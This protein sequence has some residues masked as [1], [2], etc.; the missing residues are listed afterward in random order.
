MKPKNKNRYRRQAQFRGLLTVDAKQWPFGRKAKGS[1]KVIV[2]LLK[3]LGESLHKET[4][5]QTNNGGCDQGPRQWATGGTDG[6]RPDGEP[7]CWIDH[8]RLGVLEINGE[9]VPCRIEVWECEDGT[10][11]ERYITM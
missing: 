3:L 10:G 2:K 9:E 4:F 7:D 11:F 6:R 8:I 1:R 5:A